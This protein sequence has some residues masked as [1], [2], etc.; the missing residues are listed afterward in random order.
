MQKNRFN[1][2]VE[3]IVVVV[4][5]CL[6]LWFFC[7]YRERARDESLKVKRLLQNPCK[8]QKTGFKVQ[9]PETTTWLL[10][11]SY[12]RTRKFES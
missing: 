7:V 2:V 3:I 12:N 11:M 4:C 1:V 6:V 10:S 9:G 8:C 5:V